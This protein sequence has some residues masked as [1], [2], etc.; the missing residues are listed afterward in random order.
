MANLFK[1]IEDDLTQSM[2]SKQ[3]KE[4]SVLRMLLA[5]LKNKKIE[6]RKK[7]D[8]SDEEVLDVLKSEEKKRK[9]SI[10]LY[11]EGSRD[12]L[13]EK[14]ESEIKILERYMPEKLGDEAIEKIVR[15][16]VDSLGDEEKANFGKVMGAVMGK[17]KGQADGSKVGELVKKVLSE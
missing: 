11:K 14:E 16:I 6:L 10:I 17:V 13:V 5:S 3:E 12:D 15:E 7:D 1:T 9:D 2:R 8:L 4:V